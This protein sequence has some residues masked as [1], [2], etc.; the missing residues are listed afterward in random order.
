MSIAETPIAAI[1]GS[2][3]ATGD[4]PSGGAQL[5]KEMD[6]GSSPAMTA[7]RADW[8]RRRNPPFQAAGLTSFSGCDE[9]D[10]EFDQRG[11]WINCQTN[12]GNHKKQRHVS[13]GTV[14][15]AATC[16]GVKM[17]ESGLIKHLNE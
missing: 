1:R 14:K 6:S 15:P 7:C 11:Q 13:K 3:T 17:N 9:G 4:G 2:H 10:N 5:S 16:F 8:S 12:Y